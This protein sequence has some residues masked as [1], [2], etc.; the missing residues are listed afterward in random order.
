MV[1][2]AAT[3]RAS[4]A[5]VMQ[6]PKN[7]IS[8]FISCSEPPKIIFSSRARGSPALFRSPRGNFRMRLIQRPVADLW[9]QGDAHLVLRTWVTWVK[10]ERPQY[11]CN[12]IKRVKPCVLTREKDR[13][14]FTS[15]AKS[16]QK[17][18]RIYTDEH[19]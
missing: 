12:C 18:P 13:R 17:R 2:C 5:T 1:L 9:I 3:G 11:S 10:L 7:V 4:I 15:T 14:I 8:F 16:H 6:K 19:G